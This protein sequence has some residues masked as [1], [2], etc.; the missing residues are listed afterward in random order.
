MYT[1]MYA[2]APVS[3]WSAATHAA[4]QFDANGADDTPVT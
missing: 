2:T 1:T 3:D 4:S